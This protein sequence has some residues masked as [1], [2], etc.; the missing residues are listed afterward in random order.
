MTGFRDARILEWAKEALTIEAEGILAVREKIG[1][2]FEKAIELFARCQG[3]VITTG[4]GKS[5][6][7][8]RKIAATLSSTGTPAFFLHPVEALHGDLGMVR[9]EDIILAIS[10]SGETTELFEMIRAVKPLGILVVTLA[11]NLNSRLARL[12]DVVIDVGV[13]REACAFGLAPTASTT[14]ALAV[15]DALAVVLTR[16]KNFNIN[17]FRNFHPG[18]HLGRRLMVPVVQLMKRGEN[19]PKVVVGASMEEVIDEM[20]RKGLGATLV[21]DKEG[22]LMGIFTDGDLR[23]AI[24]RWGSELYER[25]IE[26]VMT[27]D[28]KTVTVDSSVADALQIMER[29]LITV[30]PVISEQ[31]SVEGILH[32]H[33]LLGKGQVEFRITNQVIE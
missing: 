26:D 19:I 20:N 22:K 32:L 10:N 12:S 24:T 3:R 33:D 7:V 14:A 29:F 9:G 5:G 16:K 4:I 8:A 2:E 21:M 1:A 28:P 17:D 18:G 25:V 15:G 11:G 23:R 31:G 6:I 27:R 13:P 30:L